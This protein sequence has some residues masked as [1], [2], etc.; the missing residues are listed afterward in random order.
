MDKGE[1]GKPEDAIFEMF[2][3]W[4]MREHN[5][6]PVTWNVLAQCLKDANFQNIADNIC[7]V[8]FKL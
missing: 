8:T 5:L 2:S 4:L 7:Y 1:R 3:R 6:K